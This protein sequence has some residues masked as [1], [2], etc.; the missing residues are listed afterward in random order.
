[1]RNPADQ[2]D[3]LLAPSSTRRSVKKAKRSRRLPAGPGAASAGF[4]LNA[5]RAAAAADKGE[6]VLLVRN[7]TS[8]EDLRG[9]IAAEGILT[10]E[11]GVSSHAALVAR[12]MGKVCICG[13]SACEI[14]Y[15]TRTM[16][17]DGDDFKEGDFLSIDGTAGKVYAGQVAT[18]PCEIVPALYRRRCGG[19]E[20][21]EVQDLQAADELVLEGHPD[22]CAPT[23]TPPSR[24]AMPSRSARSVSVSAAPS[25]C[26]SKAIES[27]PCAR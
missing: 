9:M 14:D 27:T 21:G 4:I 16:T 7:E 12:Q 10:G 13:A 5:D 3:Q 20:D 18:A 1:M 17:V 23:P 22:V 8:P 26:S 25:T 15:A 24:R 19:A 6:K 11:G 2:L